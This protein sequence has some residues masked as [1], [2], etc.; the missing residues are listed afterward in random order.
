MIR[1]FPCAWKKK[2]AGKFHT[3]VK[4]S[5]PKRFLFAEVSESVK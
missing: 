1:G 2:C 4:R 5:F 3:I